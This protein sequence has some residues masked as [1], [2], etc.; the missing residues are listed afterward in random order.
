M[1]RVSKPYKG[2]WL[3][4]EGLRN[5]PGCQQENNLCLKEKEPRQWMENA[6]VGEEF[7]TRKQV[8]H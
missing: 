5:C 7:N 3:Y 8:S 6:Q 2:V 1:Q 4:T